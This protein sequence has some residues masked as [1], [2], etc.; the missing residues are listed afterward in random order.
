MKFVDPRDAARFLV[1]QSIDMA[2]R[3]SRWKRLLRWMSRPIRRRRRSYSLRV[4]GIDRE[5]GVITLAREE[6]R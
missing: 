6:I 2:A 3:A 5:R 4:V 1:G